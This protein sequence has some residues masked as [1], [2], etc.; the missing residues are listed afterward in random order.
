LHTAFDAA[1]SYKGG[2]HSHN[3]YWAPWNTKNWAWSRGGNF[4][5][6][7]KDIHSSTERPIF[8]DE[9]KGDYT[10]A[11]NSPGAGK[12][13]DGANIGIEWNEHLTLAKFQRLLALKTQEKSTN[14]GTSL[15]FS[16]LR[17]DHEYLV[18]VYIPASNFFT[19]TEE[20]QVEGK[21]ISRDLD[22]MFNESKWYSGRWYSGANRY[23]TLGNHP[24][25]SDGVLNVKWRHDNAAQRIFIRELPTPEQAYGWINPDSQVSIP[26]IQ[27][28]P[29]S[30]FTQ[31]EAE[32]FTEV[33]GA[34]RVNTG[35]DDDG[36]G[37][38]DAAGWALYP[39]VDFGSGAASVKVLAASENSGIIKLH[40]GSMDGPLVG[41]CPINNTGD[42]NTWQWFS[43]DVRGAQG[44]HDLFLVF[45]GQ[46]SVRENLM[47]VNAFM[48][49][50]AASAD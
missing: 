6:T 11:P 37:H 25:S 1:T 3:L 33:S 34:R 44:V 9:A 22:R 4:A 45:E 10:L 50:Q 48:F 15:S 7:S 18:E 29:I 21:K 14:G 13:H 32:R 12:G 27:K 49:S 39:N 28:G 24:I 5:H 36:I 38:I 26:Q 46:D 30:A 16:G 19:G 47:N 31:I 43:A 40:L 2:D 20:Y 17:P 8:V 42:W 35:T 23:V 41:T